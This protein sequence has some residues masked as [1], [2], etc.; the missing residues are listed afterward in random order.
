MWAHKEKQGGYVAIIRHTTE[1]G[2]ES[3]RDTVKKE[4]TEKGK[5]GLA[6]M[7][8]RIV[9]QKKG[10]LSFSTGERRQGK[11]NHQR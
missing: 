1:R 5:I 8:L 3:H 2:K 10:T 7:A 6:K 9:E 11:L 4:E